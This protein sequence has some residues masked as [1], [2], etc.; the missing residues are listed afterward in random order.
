ML[1]KLSIK[2]YA[3]ID[4]VK[5]ELDKGFTAITGETG[6]GKSIL[7][8]AI[9]LLLGK[10]ADL[11]A[12]KNQDKKCI[13]E[14]EFWIKDYHLKSIFD[15]EELDYDAHSIIRREILPSGKSRLFINDTPV[16]L[17]LAQRIGSHLVDIHSQHDTLSITQSNYQYKLLDSLADSAVELSTY[18]QPLRRDK[19]SKPEL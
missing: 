2:N 14:G 10:R 16:R 3:L 9:G 4:D 5:L 11:S 19:D 6:A 1:Q 18:R 12:I 13:I 7:L 17:T 8:G 15:Q